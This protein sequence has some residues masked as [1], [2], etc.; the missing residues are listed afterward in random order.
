MKRFFSTESIKIESE[1][2]NV[3]VN[4]PNQF[5]VNGFP[6]ISTSNFQE[7]SLHGTWSADNGAIISGLTPGINGP[8]GPERVHLYFVNN[9][10]FVV[11]HAFQVATITGGPAHNLIFT[12]S[13][14]PFPLLVGNNWNY[15]LITNGGSLDEN[16]IALVS[17]SGVITIQEQFAG[18]ITSPFALIYDTF[19]TCIKQ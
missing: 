13:A 4:T 16:C 2:V 14:S 5:T 1:Q 8:S 11:I 17:P 6:V 19:V 9:L 15:V 18:T 12:P 7:Y 10:C 3:V